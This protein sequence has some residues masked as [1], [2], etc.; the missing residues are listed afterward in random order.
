[1]PVWP[2]GGHRGWTYDLV[3]F[4]R[5]G[6]IAE[7]GVHWGTSLFAF[8]QAVKDAELESRMI[9]V[10]TWAGDG[11][12][13]PYGPDVLEA[14][15][16]IASTYFAKQRFELLPMTFDEALPRV[17]DESIDLL[18]IDGFHTY[19]AVKH[20]F[21]SW[22]PKLAPNGVVLLHDVADDTG[23]GSANYWKELLARYP[24]FNFEHSWGLGVVCPKGAKWM[25]ALRRQG[26]KDKVQL[27]TYRAQLERT[28]IE[29]R[30]T[31]AMAVSR[32]AAM[33][34]MG[35]AMGEFDRRAAAAREDAESMK[36]TVESLT[37]TR[38][39]LM[40]ERD[41]LAT[42]RASLTGQV[43]GLK[44][45]IDQSLNV[46]ASLRVDL[47][48]AASRREADA[49]RIAALESGVAASEARVRTL[50][51]RM[52]ELQTLIEQAHTMSA[53]SL[54]RAEQAER[55]SGQRA[56]ELADSRAAFA[57]VSADLARALQREKSLRQNKVDLELVNGRLLAEL[58]GAG[59]LAATLRGQIAELDALLATERANAADL[60]S[61]LGEAEAMNRE[62]SKS[63]EVVR[64]DVELLAIRLEHLER[65][66]IA[67]ET[68]EAS[69]KSK[70]LALSGLVRR[71]NTNPRSG[72]VQRHV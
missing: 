3:R 67:E 9:G 43:A 70:Q 26:L 6:V 61:E 57:D 48:L 31:G 37:K 14:V 7:L 28:R 19:D 34:E 54:A 16:T 8:A 41:S 64:A 63:L 56:R 10:D 42:E 35:K 53:R 44:S 24:G 4:M 20:D 47:G 52:R 23:Y 68:A 49:S 30:D 60:G 25:T 72:R 21:D 1:M 59:E 50:S 71:S 18:H 62:L 51:D 39:A 69:E 33:D 5:P 65:I 11:H 66:R 40:H 29:L 55:E 2:W 46:A 13:G 17:P 36:A 45:E 38:D 15:R 27:Y 58:V 22:L 12:T 32:L